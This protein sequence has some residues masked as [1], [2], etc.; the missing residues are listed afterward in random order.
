MENYLFIALAVIEAKDMFDI[1]TVSCCIQQLIPS[2]SK[3]RKK[4]N[5]IP[6]SLTYAVQQ[7]ITAKNKEKYWDTKDTGCDG[8][9]VDITNM[10]SRFLY[11][12]EIEERRWT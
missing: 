4:G 10:D 2:S 3:Q 12:V 7:Y 1:A 6:Q 9:T 8:N 5:W 11:T